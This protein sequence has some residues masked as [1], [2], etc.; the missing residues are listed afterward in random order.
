MCN[1]FPGTVFHLW[2]LSRCSQRERERDVK[3]QAL[4]QDAPW[5]KGLELSLAQPK[6]SC[7]EEN[8]ADVHKQTTNKQ[9]LNFTRERERER[10]RQEGGGVHCSGSS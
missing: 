9:L 7:Q 10:E 8:N 6:D 5:I 1:G 2:D 4:L 3:I